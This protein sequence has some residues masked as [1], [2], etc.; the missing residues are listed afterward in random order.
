[1]ET[2]TA[3]LKR[4]GEILFNFWSMKHQFWS[5]KHQNDRPIGDLSLVDFMEMI[6]FLKTMENKNGNN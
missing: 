5:M 1:M 6:A 4:Q 3:L 2:E